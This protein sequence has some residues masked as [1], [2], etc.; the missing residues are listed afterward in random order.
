MTFSTLD[1][2]LVSILE[3]LQILTLPLTTTVLKQVDLKAI[4]AWKLFNVSKNILTEE[5]IKVIWKGL[6]YASI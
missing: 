1:R 3:D 4:F 2:E 5:E 6:D